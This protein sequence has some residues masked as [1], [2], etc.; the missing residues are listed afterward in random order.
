MRLLSF[1]FKEPG[2]E[3]IG[4]VTTFFTSSSLSE[5]ALNMY[6]ILFDSDK[7]YNSYNWFR[8]LTTASPTGI[9]VIIICLFQDI[10]TFCFCSFSKILET[11]D[12]HISETEKDINKR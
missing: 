2:T 5:L 9:D 1:N 7:Q 10:C 8:F 6:K 3:N 4:K 12:N 11:L